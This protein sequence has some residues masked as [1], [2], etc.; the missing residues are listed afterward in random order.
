M[1]VG[2][3][4]LCHH[5]SLCL[6]LSPSVSPSVVDPVS[7]SLAVS[8]SLFFSLSLLCDHMSFKSICEMLR[9]R[10][11]EA[12]IQRGTW[13]LKRNSTMRAKPYHHT[14]SGILMAKNAPFQ[15]DVGPFQPVWWAVL[16]ACPAGQLGLWLL[17]SPISLGPEQPW[18][19]ESGV[20]KSKDSGPD[21][22]RVPS[23]L[24]YARCRT[25]GRE[26]SISDLCSSSSFT[27]D[28]P[29]TM[30]GPRTQLYKILKSRAS[31]HGEHRGMHMAA[32]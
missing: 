13:K 7:L 25:L 21:S 30:S 17:L 6:S 32:M 31:W 27:E 5:H 8:D 12:R 23:F 14:S 15:Q 18:A 3:R 19:G 28:L 24:L 2:S 20:T 11:N 1:G 16:E 29:P 22:H 26:E 9:V 4:S 10:E